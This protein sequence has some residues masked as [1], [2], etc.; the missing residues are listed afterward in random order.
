MYKEVCQQFRMP[1][2]VITCFNARSFNLSKATN[3]LRQ[4]N[5]KTGGDL[6]NLKFPDRM[7]KMRT[8]LIGIDVCHAGPQSVVGFSASTNEQMSQYFSDYLVQ[9]KGQEIVQDH[10]KQSIC[11]AIQEFAKNHKGKFPT[12]F[13]IFRDGVGDAQ[14]EQ[15]LQSEIPQFEAAINALYNKA[16]EKPELTVVVVNKR[17]SQRFFVKDDKGQLVNPPSGCIID[18]QLVTHNDQSSSKF[19]FF[20][21]PSGA[22][23]G[24]VLPT[25]FYVP[26]ND[27]SLTRLELEQLTYALCHFYFNWAGPIKVPAPCQYAHKIAEFYVTIGASKKPRGGNSQKCSKEVLQAHDFCKKEIEPLN[28]KLHFL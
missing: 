27:S 3:I 14:Q 15:V 5:S 1:S 4:I 8:M 9:K 12:N 24:C 17:I 18:T 23:Q 2:Q 28:T 10:M 21:T 16:A 26:R 6:Y 19:D 13:V 22:N 25:H 20:L 11:H 7:D